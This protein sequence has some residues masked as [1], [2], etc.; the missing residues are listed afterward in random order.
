MSAGGRRVRDEEATLWQHV[1]RDVTPIPKRVE[2]PDED[3]ADEPAA[4]PTQAG[5]PRKAAAPAKPAPRREPSPP[6][7]PRLD[8]AAPAG[9]D[10]RTARRLRRGQLP[11][12]ARLDLH[13]KT[14]A[15]AHEALRRFIGESRMAGRRCVQV[16]TGKGSVASG[17]GGVL[18]R[19]V[20]RWL[21]E[22]ALRRHI[23]AIANPPESGG[24]AGALNV[25]LK[26][27]KPAAPGRAP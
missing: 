3:E 5:K 26:S 15:Q 1:A 24:G 25:L 22:P 10:K 4:P 27:R 21:N 12:E 17:E 2:R 16:I 23:V 9:L 11:V 7:L 14:E 18:R 6:P 19:M 20:P 13:G 8:P